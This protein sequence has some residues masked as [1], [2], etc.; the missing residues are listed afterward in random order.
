MRS[1]LPAGLY[2]LKQVLSKY[3]PAFDLAPSWRIL[4]A[5]SDWGTC[6]ATNDCARP[7]LLEPHFWLTSGFAYN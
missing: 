3:L 1:Q 5:K 2:T 6:G 7:D 4:R